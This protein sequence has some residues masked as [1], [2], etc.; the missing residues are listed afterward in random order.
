MLYI[1]VTIKY[2]CFEFS[3]SN[4]CVVVV[5]LISNSLIMHCIKHIF[6]YLF[7]TCILYYFGM[8]SIT[9]YCRLVAYTT[10]IYIFSQLWR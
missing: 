10:E 3:R 7:A 8:A 5:V 9:K 2:Q 1:T 4:E 6:I